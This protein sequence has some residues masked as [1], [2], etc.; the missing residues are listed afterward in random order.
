MIGKDYEEF[1]RLLNKHKARYCIVGAYA[2][3]FYA[4]PRYTK[5][6]DVFMEQSQDNAKKIMAA[7]R[8]FGF[9]SLN[10]TEEDFMEPNAIIQLGYEPVRIDLV[11]AIDG[12]SFGRI[13]KNRK[14]GSYGKQKV[15]FIGL[16]DLIRNK[17]AAN[18][19]QDQ[20]DL[21][22]LKRYSG[23]LKRKA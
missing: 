5:D 18:R 6:M 4:V 14:K 10:L 20:V 9:A 12:C 21:E 23:N 19:K 2:L 16:D 3:A 11:T 13:W 22:L 8:E 17:Q 7:L 15:F 1:L